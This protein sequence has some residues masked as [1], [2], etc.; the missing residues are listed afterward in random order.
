[1]FKELE[2][3]TCAGTWLLLLYIMVAEYLVPAM[4]TLTN[5]TPYHSKYTWSGCQGVKLFLGLQYLYNVK[6]H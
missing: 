4:I 5:G 3:L 2:L 6:K 1:M